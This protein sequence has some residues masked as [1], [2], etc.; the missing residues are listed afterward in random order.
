MLK[1]IRKDVDNIQAK[2]YRQALYVKVKVKKKRFI[3]G[4]FRYRSKTRQ[5][6][7]VRYKIKVK[8]KA[9][10][11]RGKTGIYTGTSHIM[12]YYTASRFKTEYNHAL[13]QA[14]AYALDDLFG[15]W[16]K[17]SDDVMFTKVLEVKVL[18]LKYTKF[19][20]TQP[21]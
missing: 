7:T 13:N 4:K 11:K 16:I 17:N 6:K 15:R 8:I 10:S 18:R 2:N 1:I 21:H 14:K 12:N 5:A 9:V 20:P 19:V 3:V